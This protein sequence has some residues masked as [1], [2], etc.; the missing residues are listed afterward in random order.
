MG[1]NFHESFTQDAAKPPSERSTGL[2]FAAVALLIAY[3]RRDNAAASVAAISSAG[4]FALL[5]AFAP[6]LLRPLN[7]LWFRFSMLLQ[8]V[9][10]P[11]VM[12][13]LFVFVF[14]PGGLCMRI[15]SDPLQAQ[16]DPTRTTYWLKR[17]EDEVSCMRRQF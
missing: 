14:V 6:T 11:L 16:R 17:K 12:F 13:T 2:V 9:V 10:N 7:L 5:A 4:V 8:K 1:S 15:F 3:V